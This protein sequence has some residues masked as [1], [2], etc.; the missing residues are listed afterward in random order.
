MFDF[1]LN[2][3]TIKN[4]VSAYDNT[5]TLTLN[6]LQV[7][8]EEGDAI[9]VEN[10]EGNVVVNKVNATGTRYGSGLSIMNG[11]GGIGSLAESNEDEDFEQFLVSLGD[12][13]ISNSH[14]DSNEYNG[15]EIFTF[16]DV[17]MNNVIANDNGSN[18]AV[19]MQ[20]F[21]VF[22]VFTNEIPVEELDLPTLKVSN[23]QFNNNGYGD[24][25]CDG[26][27]D[28]EPEL[29]SPQGIGFIPFPF[30]PEMGSGIVS[31]GGDLSF[32]NVVADGNYDDGSF[33]LVLGD[34]TYKCSRFN[35]NGMVG[36]YTMADGNIVLKNVTASG[37]G[38][39]DIEVSADG[40]VTDV[41]NYVCKKGKGPDPLI[42]VTGD[43]F[44]TIPCDVTS[45]ELTLPNLDKAKYIGL[46]DYQA[47]LLR[48]VK[49]EMPENL[50][51]GDT[52]ISSFTANLLENSVVQDVVPTGG[53]IVVEFVIPDEYKGKTLVM[54]YWDPDANLGLGEWIEV[55]VVGSE[56]TF[57]AQNDAKQVLVGV[58]ISEDG[59]SYA[60]VNFSGT[61][62]LVAK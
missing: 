29:T 17:S 39:S 58:T 12:V 18:G 1:T 33:N 54:L 46:C 13:T 6:D 32:D 50:P 35:G 52:F 45:F 20:P 10:Q 34:A 8:N 27:C 23:S 56:A 51:E 42:P 36:L 40:T 47:E 38:D 37:N 4:G 25:E 62:V 19:V 61:F 24:P 16:G 44:V 43:D 14:F 55:P 22:P 49:N 3:F 11:F 57:D 28:Y 9:Y 41:P 2:G 59:R 26:E 7:T 60:T 31:L 30:F 21:F 15:I 53:S 48:V 5:G